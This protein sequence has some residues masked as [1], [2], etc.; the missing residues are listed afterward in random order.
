MPYV[1][2]HYDM[3]QRTLKRLGTGLQERIGRHPQAFILGCMGPDPFFFYHLPSLLPHKTYGG[4]GSRLHDQKVGDT[5]RALVRGV[6]QEGSGV[7]F[8][9]VAGFLCHYGLDCAA[10]PYIFYEAGSGMDH[11]YFECNLDAQ[12]M[13]HNGVKAADLP[14][15][16]IISIGQ[17]E[18]EALGRL[19]KEYVG[20]VHGLEM[21]VQDYPRAVQDF[22]RVLRIFYNPTGRKER[23]FEGIQ[24]TMHIPRYL[25]F[26]VFPLKAGFD[27]MNLKGEPW[28]L[29]WSGEIHHET[30]LDMMEVGVKDAA[31]MI[32]GLGS[33][34]SNGNAESVLARIGERNFSTG[35]PWQLKLPFIYRREP[36]KFPKR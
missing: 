24:R 15:Y 31:E 17:E 8:S 1:Y 32:E 12:L 6:M 10:H 27:A 14:Q 35:Q 26:N 5:M 9:Y 36:P 33:A 11:T 4:F 18:G 25:T 19:Y 28:R 22:S 29:P 13:E 7:W 20:P 30:F 34:V 16:R 23:F 2:A 3:G 21:K